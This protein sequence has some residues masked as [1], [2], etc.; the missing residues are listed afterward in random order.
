MPHTYIERKRSTGL[1][2]FFFLFHPARTYSASKQATRGQSPPSLS[3]DRANVAALCWSHRCTTQYWSA[4]CATGGAR[5]R[6]GG[7]VGHDNDIDD[8][9]GELTFLL[10]SV[11]LSPTYAVVHG[12]RRH[13]GGGGIR[14]GGYLRRL[15]SQGK[16]VEEVE[17]G[18][19]LL[20]PLALC[21]TQSRPKPPLLA[22]RPSD[23]P[24]TEDRR[25]GL[26]TGK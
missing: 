20:R 23:Q 8:D 22:D 25:S 12:T 7:G 17:G 13:D 16:S 15:P 21:F 2:H 18:W 6:G 26:A 1:P 5:A 19:G 11:E 10:C 9:D 3:R 14:R 4:R 24:T